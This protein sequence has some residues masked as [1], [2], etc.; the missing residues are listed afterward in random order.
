[1]REPDV[2][3]ARSG[4]LSIAYQV[5]G[6][7]P[8]DVVFVRGGL[9][10]MLSSWERP[11]FHALFEE[12]TS[13]ARVLL[14][15]TRGSGL[16]D[17]A[18]GGLALDARMDDVRAVMDAAGSDDAVLFGSFDGARLALMFAA[19]YPERTRGLV[20]ID[21]AA[22][23]RRSTAHPWGV[24]PEEADAIVRD[25]RERWGRRELFDEWWP[26]L[27]EGTDPD[28]IRE[29]DVRRFR[30]AASP[31]A[32]AE[33]WRA[34]YE[35]DVTDVLSSVRV[36]TTVIR[37]A[38]EPGPS[39]FVAD[40]V[41]DARYLE[42]ESTGGQTWVFSLRRDEIVAEI[43]ARVDGAPPEPDDTVLA[44]ILFT[45]LVASTDRVASVG[46]R[47][48]KELVERHRAVVR[49]TLARFRGTE[50]EV[51]GDGFFITFDGAA[52]AIR[53]AQAI[54][55]RVGELGLDLRA[56]LH[57]GECE[58]ADGKVAGIAVHIGARVSSLAE[59]REVLVTSTVRDLVGGSGIRF[60]DRGEH[61]LK[62]VPSSWRVYRVVPEGDPEPA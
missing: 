36:P 41:P 7:G 51:A 16:S 34:V 13:F 2:S 62:G 31:S 37:Y 48:W 46:D 12:L 59:G 44:T 50:V 33:F 42:V 22:T 26:K 58:V 54:V 20:L 32:A 30:R 52:R 1:M 53:C 60:E 25:A 11:E 28:E 21:V 39:R 17:P 40:H 35:T 38:R 47:A 56:G 5:V 4:P 27:N 9:D 19:T 29:W 43:R 61:A 49:E 14:F 55:E 57:T 15:D 45:D 23:D 6:D 10:D 24:T 18:V 8:R 3:Y